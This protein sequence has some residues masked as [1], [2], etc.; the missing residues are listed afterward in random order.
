MKPITSKRSSAWGFAFGYEYPARVRCQTPPYSISLPAKH[1]LL[2]Q[3]SLP[4]PCPI[5][6][7]I[8]CAH[9]IFFETHVPNLSLP[10]GQKHNRAAAQPFIQH[11]QQCVWKCAQ[12]TTTATYPEITPSTV[13]SSLNNVHPRGGK[14]DDD[15]ASTCIGNIDQNQRGWPQVSRC[16]AQLAMGWDTYWGIMNER[17]RLWGRRYIWK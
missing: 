4:L 16:L 1:F 11:H 2:F 3:N 14:V 17:R 15:S 6:S 8:K 7:Q 13:S 5:P 9:V 12:P 10:P